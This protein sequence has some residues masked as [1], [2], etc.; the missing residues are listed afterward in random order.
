MSKIITT[1]L[2]IRI[3][4]LE[5]FKLGVHA[6][7]STMNNLNQSRWQL[8]FTCGLSLFFAACF[9]GDGLEPF[10]PPTEIRI[11]AFVPSVLY[12]NK[13]EIVLDASST[14]VMNGPR[15][16]F[17]E[18]TCT[19]YP[20]GRLP[21]INQP[22][23]YKATA[24]SPFAGNYTFRLKVSDAGGHAAVSNYAIEVRKDTLT[25]GP[26]MVPLP[27][28]LLYLP[29]TSFSLNAANAYTVNPVGRDLSFLWSLIQ[30]PAG[31]GPL[32]FN[33]TA[34]PLVMVE[35]FME[36]SY[37]FRLEITNEIG[38]SIA[39]TMGVMVM[40][41]T[42]TGKIKIYEDL[43][44]KGK[45]LWGDFDV[46]EYFNEI[47]IYEPLIFYGRTENT[48]DIKVWDEFRHDWSV[49]GVYSWRV[50]G[51]SVFLVGRNYDQSLNGKK[52]KIQVKFL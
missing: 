26:K 22:K 6:K 30:Q 44:W 27:D 33:D 23:S 8:L 24:D 3:Y 11:E 39:D 1:C 2:N 32:E 10:I 45:I 37:Q 17:F 4:I 19:E 42:L 48:L 20:A 12:T 21:R 35:G 16:L 40:K 28:Q 14:L 46:Y 34:K 50:S 52:A 15:E 43:V 36:G 9:K 41:D 51:N 29:R 47:E 7:L 38:L 18:W 31:S 25:Q 5:V 49:P 13:K